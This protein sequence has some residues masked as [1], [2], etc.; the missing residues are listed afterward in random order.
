MKRIATPPVV[1]RQP[2]EPSLIDRYHT[3]EQQLLET[4]KQLHDPRNS[5]NMT[6]LRN[7]NDCIKVMVQTTQRINAA[8]ALGQDSSKNR[9]TG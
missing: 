8:P 2:Q 7:A 3:S 6:L 5:S 9:L 4:V 1:T